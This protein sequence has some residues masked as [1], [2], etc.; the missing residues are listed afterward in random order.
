SKL[1]MRSD[2]QRLKNYYNADKSGFD[3]EFDLTKLN[4]V[5][6]HEYQIVSRYS[7][8]TNGEGHRTDVWSD[9]YKFTANAGHL[10]TV[11]A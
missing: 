2:V 3:V 1:V 5:A 9:V 11:K 4:F 7:D 10:D 6:G 8:A